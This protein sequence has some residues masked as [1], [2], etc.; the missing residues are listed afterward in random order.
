EVESTAGSRG[1]SLTAGVNLNV[2]NRRTILFANYTWLRQRN[3]ADGPFSLPA[4]SYDLA[5]EWGPAAGVPH[6]VFSGMVNTAFRRNL[7]VGLTMTAHS[8]VP[9][10]VTTGRDD[11][12]DTVFNDRPVG[13]SHNSAWTAGM[14]DVGARVSYAFGFGSRSA[15]G[16]MTGGP[17]IVVQR[18]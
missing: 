17:T 18:I 12:G 4:N 6:H 13:T 7:R 8:G 14:W 15:S 9:Y 1:D 11:N 16:G 2:P 10:N 3:D 5:G